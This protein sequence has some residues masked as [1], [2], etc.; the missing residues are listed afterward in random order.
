M[1]FGGDPSV[2]AINRIGCASDTSTRSRATSS[3]QPTTPPARVP[4]GSG[5]QLEAL[6]QLVDEVPVLLVDHRA[7]L[8]HELLAVLPVHVER[9][10][11]HHHVGAVRL[12]VDVLVHPAELGLE[13]LG[14]HAHRAEHAEPAGA[15]H[16][17]GDVAAVREREDRVLDADR[18]T[19]RCAHDVPLGLRT[20]CRVG[21][22]AI[23]SEGSPV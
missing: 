2:L 12:A 15:A 22:I 8:A 4:S 14:A 23:V 3:V 20:L 6:H 11:R 10:L 1:S 9:L 19:E 5:G 13:L 7:D 16:R 21:A 18:V 17:G